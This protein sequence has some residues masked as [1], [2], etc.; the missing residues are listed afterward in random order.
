VVVRRTLLEKVGGVS[1]KRELIS[2]EDYDTWIR[3]SLVT[4][5]FIRI[6]KFLG[7]YWASD[8]NNSA[9]SPKQIGNI[10]ELYNQYLDKLTAKYRSRAEGLLAYRVGRIAYNYGDF[11]VS[12]ENFKKALSHTLNNNTRAK[13]IYFLLISSFLN[14]FNETS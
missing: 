3:I 13:A 2:V 11:K 9:A 14:V 7:Y 6:P 1:E 12:R 4:D 5:R 8:S 10:T